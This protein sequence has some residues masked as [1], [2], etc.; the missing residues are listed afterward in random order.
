MTKTNRP[1]VILID[2]REQTP[3]EFQNLSSE[4]ATLAAGDYSLKGLEH[5]IA[6]ERKSL[7]DLLA[8]IGRERDRFKRELQRLRAYR[9]RLLLV[10]T[11]AAALEAGAWR[12]EIQPAHVLGSL[13][14]W[15]AQFGLPVWLAGD[16]ARAGRF[17]ERFLFQCARAVLLENGAAEIA[18]AGL[19]PIDKHQK[20]G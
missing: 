15:T 4:T 13:A 10:E 14:A 1:P 17:L 7:P 5:L 8:C 2:S 19:F 9:F 6:V 16:H 3:L 11:D 18:A 12:G 20:S